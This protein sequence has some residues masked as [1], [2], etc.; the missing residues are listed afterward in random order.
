M[1]KISVIVPV[2][3]AEQWLREALESLQA[4]TY[5]DFEAIMVDDGSTDGSGAICRAFH[6]ADPRF[7]LIS[8]PNAGLSAARNAGLDSAKGD[9]ISFLDADD[10]LPPDALAVMMDHAL[11]SGAGIVTGNYIR[12]VPTTMPKGMGRSIT[13]ASDTAILIGLYQARMLNSACGKL[14]RA[15]VFHGDRPL[16]F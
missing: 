16:R 11:K 14:Y 6:E 13:V 15:S 9:W 5:A 8:Q 4:Q 2:Y 10:A 12:K 1:E 3:N 7:R